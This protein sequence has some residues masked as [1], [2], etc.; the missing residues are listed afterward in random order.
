MYS[1]LHGLQKQSRPGVCTGEHTSTM[2]MTAPRSGA[3]PNSSPHNTPA[4]A[5][6]TAHTSGTQPQQIESDPKSL[7]VDCVLQL[8]I[9]VEVDTWRLAP[10]PGRCTRSTNKPGHRPCCERC[11]CCRGRRDCCGCRSAMTQ[12]WHIVSGTAWETEGSDCAAWYHC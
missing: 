3:H 7:T 1:T 9:A 2:T 8:W 12:T 6:H 5:K 4:P 11:R 10:R